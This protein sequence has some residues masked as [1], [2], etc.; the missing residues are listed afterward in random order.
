[1]LV[2]KLFLSIQKFG[3]RYR[4]VRESEFIDKDTGVWYYK[5]LAV[6]YTKD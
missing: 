2:S 3:F 5:R 4:I 1:M 6:A